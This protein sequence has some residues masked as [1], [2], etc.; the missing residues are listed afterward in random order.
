M[1][2]P[3][4]PVAPVRKPMLPTRKPA[5]S[6]PRPKTTVGAPMDARKLEATQADRRALGVKAP[7]VTPK[8]ANATL[9]KGNLANK[10][11]TSG[12]RPTVDPNS[13]EYKFGKGPL[14][15]YKAAS[16]ATSAALSD[17]KAGASATAPSQAAKVASRRQALANYGTGSRQVLSNKGKATNIIKEIEAG[18]RGGSEASNMKRIAALKSQWKLK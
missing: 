4:R 17:R 3:P 5:A 2:I 12:L 7:T 16:L 13:K 8:Q 1:A 14:G 9:M 6:I 15:Q 11:I 10:G 18:K